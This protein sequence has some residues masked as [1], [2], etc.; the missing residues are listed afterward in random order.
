MI[1]AM[2]FASTEDEM[3]PDDSEYLEP[4]F[5]KKT[6]EKVADEE[7]LRYVGGYM[8]FKFPEYQFLGFKLEKKMIH[9][10]GK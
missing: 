2:M 6:L 8:A 9:G 7:G 10:S 1:S 5:Q 3:V 4:E